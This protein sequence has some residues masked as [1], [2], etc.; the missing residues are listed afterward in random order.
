M[1]K[2]GNTRMGL[3]SVDF[4]APDIVPCVSAFASPVFG[5]GQGKA[6][7]NE[8]LIKLATPIRANG[9]SHRRPESFHSR[10]VFSPPRCFHRDMPSIESPAQAWTSRRLRVRRAC[11]R[12]APG[13]MRPSGRD[14]NPFGSIWTR[15]VSESG[16]GRF[17]GPRAARGPGQTEPP[18]P[19]CRCDWGWAT[20]LPRISAR[21]WQS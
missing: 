12:R 1:S 6:W 3:P 4:P 9:G 18:Q 7:L 20:P 14:W 21:W 17:E 16:I 11:L 5:S 10:V 19:P 8:G 15:A 13:W 2:C